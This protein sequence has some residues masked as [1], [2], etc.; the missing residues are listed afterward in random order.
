MK[1]KT[2]NANGRIQIWNCVKI[3][4]DSNE[5]EDICYLQVDIPKI[6]TML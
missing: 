6:S 4:F 5:Y 3:T 1:K 2:T